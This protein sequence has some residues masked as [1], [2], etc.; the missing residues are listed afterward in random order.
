MFPCG[1]RRGWQHRVVADPTGASPAWRDAPKRSS[2]VPSPF[3]E[4]VLDAVASVPS[5]RV[6]TYGDVAALLAESGPRQVGQVLAH[7]GGGVP[8]HRVV[9]ADGTP[10]PALAREALARLRGEG[11]PLLGDG[12]RVDLGR[13][14]WT[15]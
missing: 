7:Y 9:R 1:L 6:T 12:T 11:V 8:W 3:A 10:P 14:R 15:G 2:G 5:G 4:R 13:S